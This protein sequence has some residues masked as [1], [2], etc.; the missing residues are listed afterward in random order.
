[1]TCARCHGL[2]VEIPSLMWSSSNDYQPTQSDQ[3]EGEAW[4]CLNCGNYI[5]GVILANRLSPPQPPFEEEAAV[6]APENLVGGLMS[7]PTA[8]NALAVRCFTQPTTLRGREG[9]RSPVTDLTD[10]ASGFFPSEIEWSV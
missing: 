9:I 7:G 6:S 2:L 3:C 8:G 4:Q 1:M 5:D 10:R